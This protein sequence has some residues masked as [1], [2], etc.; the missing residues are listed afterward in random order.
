MLINNFNM[1]RELK[2]KYEN[3][4]KTPNE[5]I[6]AVKDV[7]SILKVS[8][9]S[10][11]QRIDN[12]GLIKVRR[13]SQNFRIYSYNDI[14]FLIKIQKLVKFSIPLMTIKTL[15]EFEKYKGRDPELYL[16]E[17]IEVYTKRIYS[18]NRNKA[19]KKK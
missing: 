1:N 8:S 17:I 9:H 12:L 19:R 11:V 16:N 7:M 5:P 4:A 3:A 14:V 10:S 6:F 13:N 2:I 18:A 15:I